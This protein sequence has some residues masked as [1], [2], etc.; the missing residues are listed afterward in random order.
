MMLVVV[1]SFA[2][3]C[4]WVRVGVGV[5]VCVCAS[6]NACVLKRVGECTRCANMCMY[7]YICV[8]VCVC[9]CV[10]LYVY[11]CVCVC[12]CVCTCA[13]VHVSMYVCMCACVTCGIWNVCIWAVLWGCELGATAALYYMGS[14]SGDEDSVSGMV[15]DSPISDI[16]A[17]AKIT[18][19]DDLLSDEQRYESLCFLSLSNSRTLELYCV[20]VIFSVVFSLISLGLS[21]SLS[22]THLS[23]RNCFSLNLPLSLVTVTLNL[24]CVC[25][26]TSEFRWFS[27]TLVTIC[28]FPAV[29]PNNCT[30]A[31]V[32]CFLV[33]WLVRS[34]THATTRTCPGTVTHSLT[35]L[36]H[37]LSLTLSHAF[38]VLL[39]SHPSRKSQLWK[40]PQ[41]RQRR[42]SAPTVASSKCVQTF[43]SLSQYTSCVPFVC[44]CVCVC[45]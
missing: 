30:C 29:K 3:V 45:V 4:M 17:L 6:T 8:C 35:R 27:S 34:L 33:S 38:A 20:S 16:K 22:L 11:A 43:P 9:V 10:C 24:R 5:C 37:S 32:L 13:C 7:V 39:R 18:R 12:V 23:L 15:L 2:F 31:S 1:F 40:R 41:P 19:E 14:Q 21:L 42:R 26:S 25:R 44:V 28:C 36:T